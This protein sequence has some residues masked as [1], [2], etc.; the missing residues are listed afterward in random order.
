MIDAPF[1][2]TAL[3][4]RAYAEDGFFI[5]EGALGEGELDDISDAVECCVARAS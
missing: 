4:K 1:C 3:E 5:R 2:L